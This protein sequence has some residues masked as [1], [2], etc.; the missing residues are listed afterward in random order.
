[1]Y[2]KHVLNRAIYFQY[3][4]SLS[5]SKMVGTFSLQPPEVCVYVGHVTRVD[6][7]CCRNG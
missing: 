3:N 7:S 1:M 4:I 5:E 2:D 6:M